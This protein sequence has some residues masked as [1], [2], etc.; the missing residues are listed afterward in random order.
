MTK[1][2]FAIIAAATFFVSCG[3]KKKSD[4]G[5]SNISTET[6]TSSD[7]ESRDEKSGKIS[8]DEKTVTGRVTTQYFGDKEKGNFSV[9][10]QHNE[11]DASNPNF[12]LL[13]VT[14]VNEKDATNSTLK[15]Y[16]GSMLPMTEP[17]AGAVTVSLSGVGAD[18]GDKP[19]TGSS[20]ST[21]SIT[22]SDRTLII[23]DMPLYDSDGKIKT[24][25]AKIPF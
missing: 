24:V 20:K 17:E 15:L 22:V 14:F 2:I 12:E 8:I 21:G 9:L 3:D 7:I 11:G 10:C 13:Q 6:S 19:Y 5:K 23:K 4:S 16:S 18:M 1:S 25:N